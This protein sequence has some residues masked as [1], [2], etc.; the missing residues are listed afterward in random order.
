MYE[1]S[2]PSILYNV[3]AVGDLWLVEEKILESTQ[4]YLGASF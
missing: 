1:Y 2:F 3:Q 4:C